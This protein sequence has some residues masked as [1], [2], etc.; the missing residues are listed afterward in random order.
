MIKVRVPA[1]F[2]WAIG[3][4]DSKS[5]RIFGKRKLAIF[6]GKDGEMKA[7]EDKCPHRGASLSK[8]VRKDGCIECPYHGWK[9]DEHGELVHIPTT[10]N[11]PYNSTIDTYMISEVHDIL[12]L[13]TNRVCP[14]IYPELFETGW[15]SISGSQEVDGNWIDWIANSCDIS[16]INYVHDFADEMKGHIDDI[17]I[18][19]NGNFSIICEAFVNQKAA[20][21]LTKPLQVDKCHITCEFIFPNTTVIKI[22]LAEPFEFITYTTITPINKN[23]SIMSWNF[24]HNMDIGDPLLDCFIN[25]QFKYHMKKTINEDQEIIKNIP[26]NQPFDLNVPCDAFQL[27]VI[28]RLQKMVKDDDENEFYLL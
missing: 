11:I 12:W 10:K 27:K 5:V 20:H 28:S 9:F 22:K 24:S 8:G 21:I 25:K 6:K 2:P 3:T 17:N 13:Q 14:P 26:E 15:K 23:K 18:Y 1:N 19:E 16:H 4:R 7:V